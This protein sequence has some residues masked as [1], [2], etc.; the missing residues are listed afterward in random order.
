MPL[1]IKK[2]VKTVKNRSKNAFFT[3]FMIILSIAVFSDLLPTNSTS[4]P[5]LPSHNCCKSW[6]TIFKI[7]ITVERNSLQ[8]PNK[9]FV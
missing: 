3:C 9:E 1:T 4:Q 5:C 7:L 8:V 2:H 6:S